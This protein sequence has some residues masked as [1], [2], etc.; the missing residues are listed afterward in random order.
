MKIEGSIRS[1]LIS[2]VTSARN[3]RGRTV[4]KDTIAY[5]HEVRDH[6]RRSDA[7]PLNT[8]LAELVAELECE[9]ELAKTLKRQS[10][11]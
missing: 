7:G 6:G 2:A 10:R 1:N 3:W 8:S 5:W 4:H 11:Q 9:L